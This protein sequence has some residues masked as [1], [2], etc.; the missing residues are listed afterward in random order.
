MYIKKLFRMNEL[1]EM[2]FWLR[3]VFATEMK[4]KKGDQSVNIL[5]LQYVCL[6]NCSLN[7]K[8]YVLKKNKNNKII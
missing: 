4:M 6:L 2:L 1:K 7:I 5:Q 8:T 3:S